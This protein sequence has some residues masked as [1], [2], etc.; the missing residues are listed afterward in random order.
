M[1]GDDLFTA[2]VL[3]ACAP[4]LKVISKWGTGVDSIDARL[5]S[6]WHQAVSHPQRLHDAGRR[7]SVLAYMLAFARR[8]PWMDREM[9]AGEWRKQPGTR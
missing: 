7:N 9:K 1:C 2:R 3:E 5:P 4:R 6:G 8:Q